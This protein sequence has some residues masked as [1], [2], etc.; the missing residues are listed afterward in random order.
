MKFS[1]L[2]S[3]GLSFLLL[4]N[5]SLSEDA[6]GTSV[7]RAE[8]KEASS[9]PKKSSPLFD[10]LFSDRVFQTKAV[11]LKIVGTPEELTLSQETRDVF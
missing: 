8:V 7:N 11:N 5:Y 6:K 9:F 2:S 3:G 4:A 1:K 10:W